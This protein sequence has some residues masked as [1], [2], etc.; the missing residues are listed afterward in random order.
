[1]AAD[2]EHEAEVEVQTRKGGLGELSVDVNGERVF[3]G[4][5]LWYPTPSSIIKKVRA[6]LAQ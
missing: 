1:M 6:V 5:R 4:S 2:L 3:T